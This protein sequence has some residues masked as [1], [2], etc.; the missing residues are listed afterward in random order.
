MVS[1]RGSD[2]AKDPRSTTSRPA[3]S[4]SH[5]CAEYRVPLPE[6]SHPR[7]EIGASPAPVWVRVLH[8]PKKGAS[9]A[10]GGDQQPAAPGP[11][12]ELGDAQTCSRSEFAS[13]PLS[14][15]LGPRFSGP[16]PPPG[17]LLPVLDWPPADSSL[18]NPLSLCCPHLTPPRAM[19]SPAQAP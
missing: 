10:L 19:R 16:P 1:N 18:E 15:R 2:N 12:P 14:S 5:E 8:V 3:L 17:T 11:N 7:L 4:A 6:C 13:Q 9:R